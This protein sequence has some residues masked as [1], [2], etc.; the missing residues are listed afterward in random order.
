MNDMPHRTCQH[1]TGDRAIVEFE[2]A[3]PQSWVFRPMP[4]DYGL[5]GEVEIVNDAGGVTGAKLTVQ[6]KGTN[7]SKLATKAGVQIRIRDVRYWLASPTP[8]I[9]VRVAQNPTR[10]YYWNVRQY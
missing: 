4:K 7:S 1:I 10:V 3:L 2:K 5:D 9:L 6:V 8:V